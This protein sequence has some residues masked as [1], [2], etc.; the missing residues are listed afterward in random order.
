LPIPLENQIFTKK[1]A[2]K[3][4]KRLRK[5]VLQVNVSS[6]LINFSEKLDSVY[7]VGSIVQSIGQKNFS[8]WSSTTNGKM[9]PSKSP[10]AVDNLKRSPEGINHSENCLCLRYPFIG[11]FL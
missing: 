4:L 6:L 2:I 11:W 3:R 5:T 8:N 9:T 10:N 7:L 1:A